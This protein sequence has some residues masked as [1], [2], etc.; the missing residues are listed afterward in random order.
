MFRVT[1]S[2]LLV[3]ALLTVSSTPALA[4]DKCFDLSGCIYVAK[5]FGAL[6]GR[7]ICKQALG[8]VLHCF[9]TPSNSMRGSVCTTSDGSHL[10]ANFTTISVTATTF[11]YISIPL[12]AA[13]GGF[14]KF[15]SVNSSG[16][17]GPLTFSASVAS[18]PMS[19]PV[20]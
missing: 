10:K 12:P 4:V 15:Y 13:T 8:F 6:P 16:G 20:P 3:M 5:A 11:D 7:G 19:E 9:D 18:C 14:D 2:F 17:V 1:P